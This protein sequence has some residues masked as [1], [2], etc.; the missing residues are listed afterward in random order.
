MSPPTRKPRI[1]SSA[2]IHHANIRDREGVVKRLRASFRKV[3]VLLELD[4][5]KTKVEATVVLGE[6]EMRSVYLFAPRKIKKKSQ[7]T[8]TIHNP[9]AM[10]VRGVVRYCERIENDSPVQAEKKRPF[11]RML[12]EFIFTSASEKNAM[13]DLYQK[14]RNEDYVPTQWHIYVTEKLQGSARD[15]VNESMQATVSAGEKKK[16]A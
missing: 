4:K 14:I 5:D 8:F 10:N 3:N 13:S 16:V 15:R 12:V 9:L 11:F 1:G 2:G 6:I 7:L